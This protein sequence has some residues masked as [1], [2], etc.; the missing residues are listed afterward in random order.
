M[1][2]PA[3]GLVALKPRGLV[4]D[5]CAEAD[6]TVFQLTITR[7]V[8]APSARNCWKVCSGLVSAP[9]SWMIAICELLA[10]DAAGSAARPPMTATTP[11][12]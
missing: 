8:L 1:Y 10:R 11:V 3:L 2:G 7:S 9:P 5:V 6:S 12:A 4:L